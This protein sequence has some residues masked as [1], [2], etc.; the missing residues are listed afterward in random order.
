MTITS[1]TYYGTT[2]EVSNLTGIISAY[3]PFLVPNVDEH[4]LSHKKNIRTNS[5]IFEYQR[6]T[7]NMIPTNILLNN[8]S[9]FPAY[10]YIPLTTTG[11]KLS[12]MPD[13]YTS[14][15]NGVP[16]YKVDDTNTGYITSGGY[17]S[18]FN[19]DIRISRYDIGNISSSY[20][21]GNWV[22][23]NGVAKILTVGK[24]GYST[25]KY[26]GSSSYPVENFS[27]FEKSKDTFLATLQKDNSHVYG[28]HY[29]PANI[30]INKLITLPQATINGE[31]YSNYQMPEDC[32][33]FTLKSK[34]FITFY[35][36]YYFNGGGSYPN[37]SFFSL[38][39][40]MRNSEKK[41]TE[42]RH[43][44]KVY[45][46]E[47]SGNHY[48]AYYY[49]NTDNTSIKGY[50][51]Y[52]SESKKYVNL[53]SSDIDENNLLFDSSWIETPGCAYNTYKNYIFYFEIPVNQGEF[54]LGSVNGGIGAYLLYLDI[55][56]N[57]SYVDRTEISQ[58]SQVV[59]YNFTYATGI[60][61]IQ[62]KTDAPITQVDGHPV[63]SINDKNTVSVIIEK[64]TTG[65]VIIE[66]TNAT[67]INIKDNN[68]NS[69]NLLSSYQGD[70]ITTFNGDLSKVPKSITTTKSL[71]LIDYNNGDGKLYRTTITE[72][73]TKDNDGHDVSTVA[74]AVHQINKTDIATNLNLYDE[75]VNTVPD[76]SKYGLL[77][78]GISSDG[79]GKE[80]YGVTTT[81]ADLLNRATFRSIPANNDNN[82]YDSSLTD[83]SNKLFEY[84]CRVNPATTTN[85]S[86][87]TEALLMKVAE[88]SDARTINGRTIASGTAKI[89]ELDGYS[90]QHVYRM[91]G[92]AA[93]ISS[94]SSSIIMNSGKVIILIY[95]PNKL[96][97]NGDTPPPS[98]V[99][100]VNGTPITA[101][102]Q[103]V[104][105]AS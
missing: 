38:H 62:N 27:N 39:E 68:G 93:T 37:N 75:T 45:D 8:N 32:V 94:S 48:Y 64:A 61:I 14:S 95:L 54:A 11:D 1:T 97:Q 9:S 103:E 16:N 67:T 24:N 30:N 58:V 43:I 79:T 22:S 72:I 20:L 96:E 84:Y 13:S 47:T 85:M 41:I 51:Y 28:M 29:M 56:A 76:S 19:L 63:I 104:S 2:F 40:I 98:Y 59:D 18:Q 7:K 105:V 74:S 88:V 12:S 31:T 60:Q 69:L 73:I 66:K 17:E 86:L 4:I 90:L 87:I 89:T 100:T 44:L 23:S 25:T 3:A 6:S 26:V 53:T 81:A 50:Y 33:D 15:T 65:I 101:V 71:K 91:S 78:R 82:Y 34:G 57:A 46:Y 83:D 92:L 10:A 52:D 80:G 42:I 77:R 102:D 99:I 5:E 49:E 21:S 55:G 35:A 36:G 70:T